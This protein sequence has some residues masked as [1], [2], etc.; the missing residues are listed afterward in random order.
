MLLLGLVLL[1]AASASVV[2][3]TASSSGTVN[4][5]AWGIHVSNLSAGGV[6]AAGMA[7]GAVGLLGLLMTL[8]GIKRSSRRRR[9][10]R[11]LMTEYRRLTQRPDSEPDG[12]TA[13]T[14]LAAA[15]G[16]GPRHQATG[17]A[18][19]AD[20][21]Y[22]QHSYPDDAYHDAAYHEEKDTSVWA[23]RRSRPGS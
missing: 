8:G 3:V 1:T 10:R 13:D 16:R 23:S 4:A 19:E 17:W 7:V 15:E 11:A 22:G 20:T 5:D 18:H 9:E 12:D 14:E 6:F 21:G 2:A